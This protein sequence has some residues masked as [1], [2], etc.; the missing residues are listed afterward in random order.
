M[1]VPKD[2][3]EHLRKL[4]AKHDRSINAELTHRAARVHRRAA[5]RRFA[6]KCAALIAAT[7]LLSV[8][9]ATAAAAPGEAVAGPGGV[10][11]SCSTA[12]GYPVATVTTSGVRIRIGNNGAVIGQVDSGFAIFT[13]GPSLP[14]HSVYGLG[15]TYGFWG[16]PMRGVE[17]A[18]NLD[19]PGD[20]PTFQLDAPCVP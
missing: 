8:A 17:L 2:L 19:V 9:P 10:T 20:A 15:V 18:Y 14:P 12:S 7:A 6:M 3:Y 5:E 11:L 13:I 1:R 4:A 16:G